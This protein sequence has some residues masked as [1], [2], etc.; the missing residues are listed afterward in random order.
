MGTLITAIQAYFSHSYRAED[1][2]VNLFFWRL[3]SEQGFFFTVDPKSSRTFVPHLERMIRLSDCFIAVVTRRLELVTSIGRVMLP[4]PQVVW[5]HSPYIQFENRLAFRSGK[6]RL[7]FVESGLDANLFG[8]PEEVYVFDRDILDKREPLYQLRVQEFAAT[9]QDYKKYTDRLLPPS[10]KAGILIDTARAGSAYAPE[11]VDL[12]KDALRA[13]GYMATLIPPHVTDDQQF[14]R[15]LADLELVV[16]EIRRPFVTTTALAFAHA[17]FIPNIR[18]CRLKPGESRADIQL[19]DFLSGYSVGDIDPLSAWHTLDELALEIVQH[20]QKFQQTRTLL[21]SFDAGRRYFLSA[22]RRRAK[23]FVSNA[24]TLNDLAIGLIKGFQTVNVQFFHYQATLSIGSAWQH[25]LNREL[26][27]CEVFIAL[28]SEEYHTSKWCQ[29]ELENAFERWKNKQVV[30]LPY[31]ITQARLPELIRDHIQCAFMYSMQPDEIVRTIVDTVDKYLT[32][33]EQTPAVVRDRVGAFEHALDRTAIQS[34]SLNVV[35]VVDEAVTALSQALDIAPERQS[36][37]ELLNGMCRVDVRLR[38]ILGDLPNFPEVVPFFFFR[39]SQLEQHDIDALKRL[40]AGQPTRVALIVAPIEAD[41]LP[42]TRQALDS[43]IRQVHA[44]DAVV[45]SHGD[46]KTIV[47]DPSPNA[48][49]RRALLAQVNILNYAPFVVTGAT[50]DHI[51]FGR[52]AELRTVCEHAQVASFAVIGGRRVGKTSLLGRLHRVRLS[53]VGF[54]TLYHDC[55]T[56]PTYATF[57]QTPIRDWRPDA[58]LNAELTF[59]DLVQNQ[60]QRQHLPLERPLVL[61]LD[62]VDKLI[63]DDRSNNWQLF[64]A[65]RALANSGRIHVVLGGERVLR[66]ALRDASSPL[67][68]FA[69]EMLIGRLD[70]RAAEELITQPIRQLE[71]ELLDPPGI[72]RRIYDFTSG[73]PNII[74]RLC[75]RLIEQINT[76]AI[77]RIS[78]EGVNS[79]LEDPDFIRRDFLETYFSRASALEHL[80]ALVMAADSDRRTLSTVHAA[81]LERGIDARLNQ[82]DAALERLVDLRNILLRTAGGYDFAVSAFPLIIARSRRLHDWIN[83]RREVFAH[84]GDIAPET[85]PPEL[86]G[87]LW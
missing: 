62:E 32:E 77:R 35:E 24:H 70:L 72:V 71:I 41:T 29:Y 31:L 19:P 3:F 81:L 28:I 53:A 55:A 57:L 33:I 46:L 45:L 1:R 65:L 12:I 15:E 9:V 11:V 73:H 76:A 25:E 68:N 49:F 85:A 54:R 39:A 17:R 59:G 87:R 52:E 61:L 50:P 43:A 2:N 74:Q 30:I 82:V 5:N 7:I 48:A 79:V 60:H 75:R 63:P 67:F 37:P 36:A 18:L 83:L 6:P 4:Q 21:D 56:T 84:A 14:I 66:D 64:N 86:Q 69:N 47:R 51:F 20:M 42:R 16:S 10:R 80:C 58:P 27:E 8:S 38:R 13:G 26:S 44:C 22:G 23:V 34:A 40:L 78:L